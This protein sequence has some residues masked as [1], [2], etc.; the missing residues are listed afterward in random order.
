MARQ[1][2]VA[3]SLLY[4]SPASGMIL[5][6]TNEPEEALRNLINGGFRLERVCAW[7]GTPDHYAECHQVSKD[8]V[9]EAVKALLERYDGVTVELTS[10]RAAAEVDFY[11][12][13]NVPVE[14]GIFREPARGA[15]EIRC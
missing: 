12:H 8:G 13:P 1:A 14:A 10:S 9:E 7:H 4:S 6:R 5:M 3:V 11:K 2:A 15:V